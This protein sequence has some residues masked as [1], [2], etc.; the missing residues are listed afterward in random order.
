M[1]NL[2]ATA[3]EAALAAYY[4]PNPE[5]KM[6]FTRYAA[7]LWLALPADTDYG[8]MAHGGVTEPGRPVA[9]CLV[10]PNKVP[11]RNPNTEQGRAIHIHALTHIEFVATNLAWDA[12]LRF[13]GLP[14]GYYQDWVQVA[15]EEADHYARLQAR[16]GQFGYGYGDFAAHNGL[17]EMAQRTAEDPLQRMMLVPRYLE[18]RA[19]EAVP[20]MRRKF[21][22]AGDP[23]TAQLLAEIGEEEVGHVAAGSRWFAQLCSQRGLDRQRAFLDLLEG[24]GRFKPG[25]KG[26]IDRTLRSRAGFT[27]WELDQLEGAP[28][29]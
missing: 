24:K 21:L 23:Q 16:L 13:G 17:W 27:P 29:T 12:V 4:A 5:D 10:P 26:A 3:R 9:P 11:K 15:L 6:A 2:Y 1:D 20:I 8:P 18:A 28:S 14:H 19:L 25:S 22:E 7:A